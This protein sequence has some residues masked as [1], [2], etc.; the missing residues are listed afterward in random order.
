MSAGSGLSIFGR[1]F[2][3]ECGRTHKVEPRETLYAR[4]AMGQFPSLCA[5]A[6]SGRRII[7]VMDERTH[8]VAGRDLGRG[9]AESGWKVSELLVPDQSEGRSPICDDLTKD[10][11]AARIGE[12]DLFVSVGSGVLTDLTRWLALDRALPFVSFATA[13]SMN[14][15][16]SASIAGTVRGV[17]SLIHAH[18]PAAVIADPAIIENAP[19]ALTASGLGDVL[20]KSVSTTDWRLNELLFGDYYCAHS[21][22]LIAEIEPLYAER[23]EQVKARAPEAIEALFGALLLTGVSMNMAGTSAPCSGGEHMVSH[24]LDM[25]ASLDGTE[26]DL[27]GRQVGLGTILAAELYRRVLAV[28]SPLFRAAPAEI[29][30]PFWGRLAEGVGAEYGGKVERLRAA[31]QTLRQAERWDLLRETLAPM[32]RTPGKLRDCLSRAGA[33]HTAEQIKSTRERLLQ[34]LLHGHEIR[35]RF[36]ILDLARLVGIMPN[37][38]GEIVEEWS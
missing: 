15:Y 5:R 38:A 11:L 17:K 33:A 1:T 32:L 37:A 35:S 29:D 16:A 25:M 9:L 6:A 8:A 30:R 7:L 18:A 28:E 4:G 20:A 34:A 13:A 3:C 27:H 19:A 24:T 26:H 23:P 31:A 22:S 2:F 12:A 10:A 36:T 14:G 21:V